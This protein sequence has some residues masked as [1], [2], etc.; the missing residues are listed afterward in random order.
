[1]LQVVGCSCSMLARTVD[2]TE[3]EVYTDSSLLLVHVVGLF[4][5]DVLHF[6]ALTWLVEVKPAP[7]ISGPVKNKQ[8]TARVC[9][10]AQH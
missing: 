9:R 4:S 1:M 2:R 7:Q 10:N 6:T 5:F 3:A 8:P